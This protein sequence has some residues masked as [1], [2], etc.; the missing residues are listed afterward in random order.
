MPAYHAA[1]TSSDIL[2]FL[3]GERSNEYPIGNLRQRFSALGD[4]VH[5]NPEYVG[6]PEADIPDSSYVSFANANASRAPRVYVGANDG[7]LHA[8][9]ATTGNEAWAYIPS[10]VTGNLSVLAGRPYL[11]SYF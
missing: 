5:S 4:I 2:N 10:M 11:H 1:A 7:M 8:F 6:A 9:D 3:R